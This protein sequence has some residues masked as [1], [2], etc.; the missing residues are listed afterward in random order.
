[1]L[2][3]YYLLTKPGIILGNLFTTTSAFLLGSSGHFD[4]ILYLWMATGLGFVIASACVFNN[5]IDREA[6]AKMERTKN[7]PLAQQSIANYK[8]CLFASLLGFAG[9][10]ILYCFTN[11]WALTSA[12]LGFFVYVILYSFSKY[13]TG[14]ATLIGSIA[15]AMPPVV[16][17]AAA[18]G[19]L[20]TTALLLFLI[21]V[22]WQMPH[23]FSIAI[24][25]ADDYKAASIPVLP[26]EIGNEAIK[27]HTLVYIVLFL[28]GLGG[29]SL[30][31]SVKLPFLIAGALLGLFWL[32]TAFQ[33]FKTK[34]DIPWARQMFRVSLVVIS[35]VSLLLSCASF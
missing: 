20:D 6:D 16:G 9:L 29:L 4:L 28:A 23:F 15:G 24:Y 17:Y 18:S 25:R 26:G 8:A 10:F 22:F 33:G 21:L 19:R 3:T 14:Q 1:V 12:L 30:V 13:K 27:R 11:T 2:K 31:G 35:G 32:K 7:R 34:D 5:Y